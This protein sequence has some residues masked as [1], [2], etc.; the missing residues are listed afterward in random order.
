VHA[1]I[2]GPIRALDLFCGSTVVSRMMAAY[3]SELHTNDLEPYS[4]AAAECFLKQP[5]IEQ[6]KR[7]VAHLTTMNE[8]TVFIP[9]IIC[10]MYAPQD[11][12]N[13]QPDERCFFTRE[14]ALRVDTWR[15]YVEEHVEDDVKP[16]CLIPILI[17]MSIRANSMGH[18]KSFVKK[19][20]NIRIGSFDAVGKRTTDPMKLIVPVFNPS[21]CDVTCHNDDAVSLISRFSTKEAKKPFDL[22]YL[23]PPYTASVEYAAFYFLHNVVLSN[24]RPTNFNKVTGLPKYRVKS[25]F[26][27]KD[28]VKAMKTLIEGC[29]AS[30]MVTLVSYNDEGIIKAEEWRRILEPYD[31]KLLERDY[32]RY[33]SNRGVEA[34]GSRTEV[35]E[36]LYVIRAKKSV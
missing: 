17:Q 32:N 6:E 36:Q 30:S 12:N 15:K 2:G 33:G 13:L 9:G 29:V 3:C 22:I 26:N 21:K 1:E 23:D 7:V 25:A 11:T 16:W 31:A 20:D 34:E 27:S 8:L 14:N 4:C 19:K 24:V 28:A 5:T 35:K 10:D 18:F